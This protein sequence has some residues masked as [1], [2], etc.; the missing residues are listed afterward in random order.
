MLIS[1]IKRCASMTNIHILKIRDDKLTCK[2]NY[3]S[4][5][6]YEYRDTH[7]VRGGQIPCMPREWTWPWPIVEGLATPHL[8][9]HYAHGRPLGHWPWAATLASDSSPSLLFIVYNPQSYTRGSTSTLRGTY[10]VPQPLYFDILIHCDEVYSRGIRR[11]YSLTLF[12]SLAF[13]STS[14]SAALCHEL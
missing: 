11:L 14:V 8:Y 4:Y 13:K 7:V 1:W 2:D 10:A 6:L 5:N 9:V 3:V 12:S